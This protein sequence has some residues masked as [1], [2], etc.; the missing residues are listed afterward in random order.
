MHWLPGYLSAFIAF[1]FF[2][3][4]ISWIIGYLAQAIGI[5]FTSDTLEKG[6]ADLVTSFNFS[7]SKILSILGASIITGVLI[8]IGMI[9]LVIPGLKANL[10]DKSC[11]EF[12]GF[13]LIR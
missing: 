12:N 11:C 3:G 9:A 5:K 6:Q 7:A 2:T 4:I 13:A 10:L 1:I 8:A